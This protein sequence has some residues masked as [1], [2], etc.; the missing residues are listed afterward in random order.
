LGILSCNLL[1]GFGHAIILVN[2]G[3]FFLLALLL[4]SLFGNTFLVSDNN[5]VLALELVLEYFSLAL[6]KFFVVLRSLL[7]LFLQGFFLLFSIADGLLHNCIVAN[8][9]F[10]KKITELICDLLLSRNSLRKLIKDGVLLTLDSIVTS[11]SE[12]F[13]NLRTLLVSLLLQLLDVVLIVLHSF[14]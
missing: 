2:S 1:S 12:F 9:I 8:V 10:V 4:E 7:K 5:D 3:C 11:L 14:N 13:D 6:E